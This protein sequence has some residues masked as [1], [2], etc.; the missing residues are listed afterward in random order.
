MR[1]FI[2]INFDDSFKTGLLN[3]INTLK[4]N[5]IKGNFTLSDN[6]HL[7]LVFL[8]EIEHS[9]PSKVKATIMGEKRN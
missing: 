2:A 7:T 9:S 8:G 6:L 5:G 4:R 1:L 3:I